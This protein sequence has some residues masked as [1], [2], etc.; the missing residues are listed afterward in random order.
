MTTRY[1]YV[2][3]RHQHSLDSKTENFAVLVEGRAPSGWCIFAVGR[4]PEN[5]SAVTEVGR[6]IC[7]KFLEI[8]A[9][10]VEQV[11]KNGGRL[12]MFLGTST[13]TFGGII[14]QHR[15]PW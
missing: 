5:R 12:E 8:L 10:V 1:K 2:T 9:G 7:R 15:R 4:S 11:D 13:N 3:L 14:R 6:A